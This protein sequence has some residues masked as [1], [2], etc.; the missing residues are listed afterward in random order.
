MVDIA[1]TI[2][3]LTGSLEIIKAIRDTNHAYDKNE[4]KAQ[5]A[6]LYGNLADVK[7]ALSDA[8]ME[9]KE[10]DQKIKELTE[11]AKFKGS[12]ITIEGFKYDKVEGKPSGLPYCPACEVDLGKFFRLILRNRGSQPRCPKCGNYY[13]AF[14]DGNV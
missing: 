3:A 8:Y 7:M 13:K 9:L 1:A 5:M 14:P 4:L 12:L 11:Q 10:R 6:D 2:S